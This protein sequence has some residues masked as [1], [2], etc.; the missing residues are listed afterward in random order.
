MNNILFIQMSKLH[1][2]LFTIFFFSLFLQSK[3]QNH[4]STLQ[5]G[6]SENGLKNITLSYF[7]EYTPKPTNSHF[8]IT[9]LESAIL[10]NARRHSF[11]STFIPRINLGQRFCSIRDY[12]QNIAMQY[13]LDAYLAPRKSN[14][15]FINYGYSP[16]TLFA[17]HQATLE[18][19]LGLPKGFGISAGIKFLYW[20]KPLLNYSVGVEYYI[21]NFWI[22]LK[23]Y[24]TFRE[25]KTFLSLNLGGRYYLNKTVNFLHLGLSYG[26]SPEYANYRPDLL[27]LLG[28]ES[29]GVYGLLQHQ[30]YKSFCLRFVLNYRY[31][32]Y[33]NKT[34][35]S[36][37]GGNIG[38]IYYFQSI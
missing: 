6:E 2:L 18:W 7:H 32:E 8:D 11:K 37:F 33:Q 24:L 38:L 1:T 10:F 21:N 25:K 14:Y 30:I 16:S 28:L 31:E 13:Q 34:W 26:N 9:T 22:T 12:Y 27:T 23:P 36:V 3:G 35:R 5:N 20:D 19:N 15:F 17:A 29:W 4:L